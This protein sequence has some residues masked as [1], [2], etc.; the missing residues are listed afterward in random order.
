MSTKT[1]REQG[2]HHDEGLP[3]QRARRGDPAKG[4]SHYLCDYLRCGFGQNQIQRLFSG[5]TGLIELTSDHVSRIVVDLP[6]D[7]DEQKSRSAALRKEEADYRAAVDDAEV[8]LHGARMAFRSNHSGTSP[9]Y[10]LTSEAPG[11][12]VAEE[13]FG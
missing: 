2:D 8:S 13:K 9:R 11:G 12:K 7:L 10:R 3:D 4:Y 5:A 1:T 6:D